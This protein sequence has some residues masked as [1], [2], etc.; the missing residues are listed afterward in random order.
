MSEAKI[1]KNGNSYDDVESALFADNP[2]P[3]Y[4]TLRTQKQI[5]YVVEHNNTMHELLFWPAT[6]FPSFCKSISTMLGLREQD[7]LWFT[8]VVRKHREHKFVYSSDVMDLPMLN[9]F[10][11]ENRRQT[12][13]SHELNL[14]SF[15][16]LVAN[17]RIS[18]ESGVH[19]QRST[20]FVVLWDIV[21]L[22]Q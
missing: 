16:A 15:T 14:P 19:T 1:T 13:F 20:G 12:F 21:L 9:N 10:I 3:L 11:T 18:Y 17:S 4:K 8:K 6:S 2:T 5:Q 22:K 7:V